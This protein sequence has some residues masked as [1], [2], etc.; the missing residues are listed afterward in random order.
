[1]IV[2]VNENH[3]SDANQWSLKRINIVY[4]SKTNIQALPLLLPPELLDLT[5]DALV[6]LTTLGFLLLLISFRS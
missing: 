6:P 2:N 5:L 3:E 4:K 1:M